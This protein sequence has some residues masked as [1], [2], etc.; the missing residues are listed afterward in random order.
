MTD[1]ATEAA[2]LEAKMA[3]TIHD[4]ATSASDWT[5]EEFATRIVSLL[6]LDKGLVNAWQRTIELMVKVARHR[7]EII[8]AKAGA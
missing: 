7:D 4:M 2:R 5:D 6:I 1:T 3:A 8:K